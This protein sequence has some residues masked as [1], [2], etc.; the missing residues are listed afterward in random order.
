MF[1]GG[2]TKRLILPDGTL[3]AAPRYSPLWD[4]CASLFFPCIECKHGSF[5][6]HVCDMP[7]STR[8]NDHLLYALWR[9][10]REGVVQRQ[11]LHLLCSSIRT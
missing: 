5:S 10:S 8:P 3:W 7:G 11:T 9:L 2:T 4:Q 6:D 1:L